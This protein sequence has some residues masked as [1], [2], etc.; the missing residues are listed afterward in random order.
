[1][2]AGII[3]E[4]LNFTGQVCSQSSLHILNPSLDEEYSHLPD[5]RTLDGL[6]DLIAGCTLAILGNVLDFRTYCAPNQ[7]EDDPATKEQQQLWKEFDRNNI[8]GDERMA[9]CYARGIALAVFRWIRTC[10]TVK[11]PDGGIIDDLPSMQMVDLLHSLLTYKSKADKQGLAG[12]PHCTL[13][14]LM[15]QVVNVVK[16]DGLIEKRWGQRTGKPSHSLKLTLDEGCTVQWKDAA[17]ASTSR[18][19]EFFLA[20]VFCETQYIQRNNISKMA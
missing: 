20:S 4:S 12:A 8:P 18:T 1:L 7:S 15:A 3:R 9:I 10:C 6:L 11:M 5:V 17:P 13:R 16:C 14:M 19:S 2:G